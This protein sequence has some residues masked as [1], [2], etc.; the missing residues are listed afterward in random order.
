MGVAFLAFSCV[1]GVAMRIDWLAQFRICR[2]KA[3]HPR[4]PS[5]RIQC[6]EVRALLATFVVDSTL[7]TADANPGDGIAADSSGQVTLR[8]AIQEANALTGLDTITLPAGSFALSQIGN[9]EQAAASGDL[10]I[11]GDLAING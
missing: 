11:S 8:A 1:L 7:D 3:R 9:S 2:R 5:A 6:L 10:D 4:R